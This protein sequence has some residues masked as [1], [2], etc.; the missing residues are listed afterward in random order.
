[1]ACGSLVAKLSSAA[2]P[3]RSRFVPL[4]PKVSGGATGAAT[5]SLSSW[6]KSELL[7]SVVQ[8]DTRVTRPISAALYRGIWIFVR[9]GSCACL[10][11]VEVH[12][13]VSFIKDL[14]QGPAVF[15]FR[16]AYAKT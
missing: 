2:F 5:R 14:G 8:S 12:L 13:L 15:P 4:L 16:N 6:R 1:M 9:L 3:F 11:L 7:D 10:G